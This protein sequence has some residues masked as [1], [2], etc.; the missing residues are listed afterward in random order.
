ME[1][2]DCRA[3]G[4]KGRLLALAQHCSKPAVGLWLG[5]ERNASHPAWAAAAS[6]RE[7]IFDGSMGRGEKETY[8]F[9]IP[10]VSPCLMKLSGH[11]INA[12]PWPFSRSFFCCLHQREAGCLSADL[13]S[14]SNLLRAPRDLK[15]ADVAEPHHFLLS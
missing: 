12:E 6:D 15:E 9:L 4:S 3:G 13:L 7:V 5:S 8:T 2:R 14:P 1:S 11:Q 10:R